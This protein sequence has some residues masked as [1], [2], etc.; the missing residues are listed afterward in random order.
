MACANFLWKNPRSCT[1]SIKRWLCKWRGFIFK[2]IL[3]LKKHETAFTNVSNP[4]KMVISSYLII[5]NGAEGKITW[6]QWFGSFGR[7]SYHAGS[8]NLWPPEILAHSWDERSSR[9]YDMNGKNLEFL[10]TTFC[11]HKSSCYHWRQWHLFL[12]W[13]VSSGSQHLI[14][15]TKDRRRY[16]W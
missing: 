7:S 8:K 9:S 11:D 3:G 1:M 4:F 5:Q 16:Y 2:Q 13:F 14:I 10:G 6:S 15:Y 12:D